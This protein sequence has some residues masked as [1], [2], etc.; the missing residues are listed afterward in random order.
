MK[1]D[2]LTSSWSLC[3]QSC[4]RSGIYTI[5]AK[6]S[7]NVYQNR[8]VINLSAKIWNLFFNIIDDND[9]IVADYVACSKCKKVYY[10]RS[11]DGNAPLR[12]HMET[13][14][15]DAAQSSLD[16]FLERPTKKFTKRDRDTT[17][18]AATSFIVS[19]VRPFEA[20]AGTGLITLLVWFS[21]LGYRYGPLSSDDVTDILPSPETVSRNVKVI[22]TEVKNSI[23]EEL[24]TKWK[25]GIAFTTDLWTDNYRR[26]SYLC[27][28]IHYFVEQGTKLVYK[29]RITSLK[30]MDPKKRKTHDV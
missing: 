14:N 25:G 18:S 3:V 23:K 21:H 15:N 28:A 16:D 29:S 20:V 22:G 24:A 5:E 13:H 2:C 11:S 6:I 7:E 1:T 10:Y 17:K 30:P 12:R 4:I 27:T 26:V 19:D 9:N 8:Q